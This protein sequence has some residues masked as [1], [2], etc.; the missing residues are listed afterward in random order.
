MVVDHRFAVNLGSV[1]LTVE[2]PGGTEV[3]V[4]VTT[5]VPHNPE[6]LEGDI[7]EVI[8]CPLVVMVVRDWLEGDIIEVTPPPPTF[9]VVGI[10]VSVYVVLWPY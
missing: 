2:K 3:S 8:V 6:A 4:L 7:V 5:C 1:V 10:N 9:V